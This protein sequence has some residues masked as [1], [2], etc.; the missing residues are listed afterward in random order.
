MPQAPYLRLAVQ[1]QLSLSLKM[2]SALY[3]T[4]VRQWTSSMS[5]KQPRRGDAVELDAKRSEFLE[6]TLL[7]WRALERGPGIGIMW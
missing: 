2:V 3:L 4:I 1:A 5:G 6:H 7:A